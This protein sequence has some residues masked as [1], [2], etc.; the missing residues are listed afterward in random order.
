[1]SGRSNGT[2]EHENC[3]INIRNYLVA[4]DRHR[5]SL[6]ALACFPRHIE[7]TRSKGLQGKTPITLNHPVRRDVHSIK[8]HNPYPCIADGCRRDGRRRLV[9][10]RGRRRDRV[11]GG[12]SIALEV[13]GDCVVTTCRQ[14]HQR[15]ERRQIHQDTVVV[16]TS[17][18]PARRHAPCR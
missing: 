10:H 8:G 1:M 12:G 9:F 17:T 16:T 7:G 4:G 2:Y 18:F 13:D 11:L 5:R 6:N 14:R 3:R 15:I